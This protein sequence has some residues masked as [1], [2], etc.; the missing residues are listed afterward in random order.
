MNKFGLSREKKL[1]VQFAMSLQI[2]IVLTIVII[3]MSGYA[4]NIG[5]S[6]MRANILKICFEI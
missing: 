1:N 3:I 6:I 2:L 5:N 4:L